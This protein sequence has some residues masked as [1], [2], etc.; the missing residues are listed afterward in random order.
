MP[1]VGVNTLLWSESTGPCRAWTQ[2]QGSSSYGRR[3][4]T[5]WLPDICVSKDLLLETSRGHVPA[6]QITTDDWLRVARDDTT[7]AQC[8]T[9]YY[10][11]G[12]TE[13]VWEWMQQ[14]SWCYP[15]G[16]IDMMDCEDH[17]SDWKKDRWV[18]SIKEDRSWFRGMVREGADCWWARVLTSGDSYT[19]LVPVQGS[20]RAYGI[21]I[22]A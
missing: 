19:H 13:Q 14:L 5:Y 21:P 17:L 9:P 8:E 11:H 10:L 1:A 18:F 22:T 12:S 16:L 3:I 6:G 15:F 2:G 20:W 7:S 4:E